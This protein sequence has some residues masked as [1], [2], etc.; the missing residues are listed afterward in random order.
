MSKYV[1]LSTILLFVSGCKSN[2]SSLILHPDD[3]ND[4][5]VIWSDIRYDNET[6]VPLKKIKEKYQIKDGKLYDKANIIIVSEITLQLRRSNTNAEDVCIKNGKPVNS[7]Y[8]KKHNNMDWRLINYD[9]LG[10]LHGVFI[11]ADYQTQFV[12]GNGYWKNYYYQDYDNLNDARFVLKEEGEVKH[13][14]KFG[15]WKYYN[16]EG[17]IDSIKT[18]ILKDSVD[19]RFPHCI[20]NKNEPCY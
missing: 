1:F 5:L 2:I 4:S 7:Y 8:E 20:F 10:R 11:V 15:E 6:I 17:K 12:R 19:V 18:Y 14:F 9:E 16:K 13:N 3:K